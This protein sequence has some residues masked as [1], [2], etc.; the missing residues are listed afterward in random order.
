MNGSTRQSFDPSRL[1]KAAAAEYS[2]S[3]SESE[4]EHLAPGLDADNDFGDFNP[5]K[6]RRVGGN[7]KEKAALGIFGSDSEDDGPAKKWKRTTLR[8]K[9]MN[10]VST[11][12]GSE[13]ED[14]DQ[15]SDN[16]RPMLRGSAMD[17]DEDEDED[18]DEGNTPGIGLGFGGAARGFAQNDTQ[19]SSRSASAEAPSRPA[20]RARFDGKNPLGMGFVPSSAND[21][22]LK[23]PRDDGSPTPRNKPQPSA[24][25]AKGKTNPKSF[26][27]RMMAKMGYQEGQ[28]LGREGQGR[29]VIIEANLRPQGI[30]LGAVKEKS[31]QE[32]KEEKR[33]AKLR[34][35]EVVDSDEE[36]KKRRKKAK[37]KS[38][39]AAFDSATSTPRRQKPK[40]LTAEELKAA[41][42]GLHI[43]D[44]F[45]PILDMTGPGSKMLTSTSGIMTPTTGTATPESTEVIEARK[46]VKR[47]QAD[48]LAFSDEWKSLQERKTWIDLE[49]KEKEQEMDELR[50][51]F[52]SLQ[53][54]SELVSGELATADWGQVIGC[55]Q[56]AL[57]LKATTSEIADIA[58]AAIH[59]FLREPDWDPLQEPTRFASELK[60]LSTLLMPPMS[61]GKSVS[62]WD[63]LAVNTDDIYRRH[64]KST[65]PYE[66]MMYKNW[67]P[68]AL[69]AV[70]SWDVYDPMPMLNIMEAWND[71]L[72]PFVRAQFINNIVRKLETAVS[73]WNPKSRRQSH[74]LPHIW[75][76]PWLQYLP[77]YHLDPKGTGLVADVRRKFRQLIDVWEFKKGLLPG[78]TQWEGVLGDQWRPLVMSHVLPSMG[79]YL[80]QNFSIEPSDQEPTLPVLTGIL[81]WTPMLGRRVIAEVLIQHMFPKWH[82]ILKEWL[83]LTDVNLSQVAEWYAWWRGALLKELAEVK[84]VKVEFD[85][86]LKTMAN[87]VAGA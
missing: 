70:R 73:D 30:G 18:E 62:K 26:G 74:R 35:E 31:E 49:L 79:K 42:P 11:G 10:F 45:A 12:A 46:L 54:F 36:E 24:F 81:K 50:S 65:T 21:P 19:N 48:L 44:A 61:N 85:K 16:N 32:R 27:A 15:D 57:E 4:D 40:Y 82:K 6:R 56:K 78:L 53:V 43:P 83:S 14:D 87:A 38:I 5:R 86:G 66:S 41:A 76:F 3:A 72:P 34:G 84:S 80:S 68:K 71:L 67:L 55:L 20:F 58:V 60:G 59:P 22:V 7:N 75:L 13:K 9:G 33:Q 28:G 69:A 29:N 1:T 64:H 63:S 77:S 8:N 39:G 52:E 23:N 51:D 25:S 2:S 47:A 37:K 17:Q